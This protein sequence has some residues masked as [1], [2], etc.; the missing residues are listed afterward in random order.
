[1]KQVPG[2]TRFSYA[3]GSA[4][5]VRTSNALHYRLACIFLQVIYQFA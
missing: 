4:Y 2:H 3:I 1:M 5:S